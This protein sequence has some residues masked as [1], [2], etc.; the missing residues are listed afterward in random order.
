MSQKVFER[1]E[2]LSV[3]LVRGI[4]N[5][6]PIRKSEWGMGIAA[7]GMTVVLRLQPDMFDV[8]KTFTTMSQ[9]AGEMTWALVALVIGCIRIIALGVNGSFVGFRYS[10]HLRL[11]A[12]V[13]GLMFWGNFLLA[14]LVSAYYHGGALSGII[15]YGTFCFFEACNVI[16]SASDRVASSRKK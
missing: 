2:M 12:S 5:H 3:I 1:D 7:L 6:F 9:M 15:A 16:Q 4:V 8:S 14:V 11:F 10:P 13:V